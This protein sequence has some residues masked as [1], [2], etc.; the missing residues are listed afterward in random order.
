MSLEEEE[1]KRFKDYA[2]Q[3]VRLI[4]NII[5]LYSVKEGKYK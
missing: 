1:R 2:I 3:K 4:E 5:I